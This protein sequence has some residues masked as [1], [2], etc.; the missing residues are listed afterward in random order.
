M[1]NG[2]LRDDRVFHMEGQGFLEH[3]NRQG[4][5]QVTEPLLSHE[6]LVCSYGRM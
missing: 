4:K 6:A 5:S 3:F 1:S 2:I